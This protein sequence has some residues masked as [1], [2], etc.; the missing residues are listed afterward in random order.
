[1]IEYP[2]RSR[3]A[4]AIR[5]W[6]TPPGRGSNRSGF[7]SF[8]SIRINYTPIRYSCKE[9]SFVATDMQQVIPMIRLLEINA[10][11]AEMEFQSAEWY[12]ARYGQTWQV[13]VESPACRRFLLAM[14]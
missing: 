11:L 1:M 7:W 4:S 3:S 5:M 9:H 14:L 10:A 8:M 12:R 2:W 6:N 13:C